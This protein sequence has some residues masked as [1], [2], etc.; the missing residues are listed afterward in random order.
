MQRLWWEGVVGR[1]AV[2]VVGGHLVWWQGI[3]PGSSD[4]AAWC[5]RC[6]GCRLGW[7][8]ASGWGVEEDGRVD[9]WCLRL[10]PRG[11]AVA[12]V[13]SHLVRPGVRGTQGA[14]REGSPCRLQGGHTGALRERCRSPR[15]TELCVL[16]MGLID[17]VGFGRQAL[18]RRGSLAGIALQ[19]D[20]CDRFGGERGAAN[21]GSCAHVFVRASARP[22]F[23]S[24]QGSRCMLESACC[25]PRTPYVCLLHAVCV[26][27]TRRTYVC[28][29]LLRDRRCS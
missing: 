16:H 8:A 23:G 9:Y 18:C 25:G 4:C 10:K 2:V 29:V 13:G 27:I 26:P 28:L 12:V 19:D 6:S 7:H 21:T 14:G 24:R 17:A 11:H 3:R 15:E 20:E 1:R 5:H 22:F